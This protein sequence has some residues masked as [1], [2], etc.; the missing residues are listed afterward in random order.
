MYS[1]CLIVY[2]DKRFSACMTRLAQKLDASSR[3]REDLV[4]KQPF[5]VFSLLSFCSVCLQDTRQQ[6]HEGCFIADDG[7]E[8]R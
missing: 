2:E 6:R 1:N 3:Q 8:E 7:N 5:S 4:K